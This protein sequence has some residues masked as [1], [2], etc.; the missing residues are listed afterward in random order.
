MIS[1]DEIEIV[2]AIE[3]LEEMLKNVD[4]KSRSKLLMDIVEKDE[5]QTLRYTLNDADCTRINKFLG[6][7]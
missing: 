7:I 6:R 3:W 4:I 1:M 5:Y 2:E